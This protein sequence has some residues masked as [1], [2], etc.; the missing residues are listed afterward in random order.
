MGKK[1][2]LYPSK[3]F[4]HVLRVQHLGALPPLCILGRGLCVGGNRAGHQALVV[5]IDTDAAAR[6]IW[7]MSQAEV[8][9]GGSTCPVHVPASSS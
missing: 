8:A 9:A 7:V 1:G 3:Y 4:R 2:L 6:I 5:R